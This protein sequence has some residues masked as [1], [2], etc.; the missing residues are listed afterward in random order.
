MTISAKHDL[1]EYKN[2]QFNANKDITG[3]GVSFEIMIESDK[4]KDFVLTESKEVSNKAS[5]VI[6]LY[7]EFSTKAEK[8]VAG[9]YISDQDGKAYRLNNSVAIPGYK[10]DKLNKIPGQM[11]RSH[12]F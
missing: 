2:K 3:K 5:G 7:N 6:T 12:R 8:L 9:T 11:P 4:A 1:I 10:I